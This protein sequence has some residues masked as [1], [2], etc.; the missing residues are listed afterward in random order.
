MLL[1]SNTATGH[2][3]EDLLQDSN[4]FKL[5]AKGPVRSPL[6][7]V[8]LSGVH[9]PELILIDLTDWNEA[10]ALVRGLK[11]LKRRG[12]LIGFRESWNRL[13]Q[14]T[15]EDA[16]IGDLLREP[17]GHHELE[18]AT[19]DA[20]HRGHAVADRN[21]LALLPAKAG[22]G[23]STVA[24]NVAAALAGNHAKKVL[25]IESDRRSG[26]LS[27]ML[28][29][30]NRSGLSEA[31]QQAGEMTPV[32]WQQHSVWVSGIHL[33]P[34]N[35]ARRGPPPTWAEYYQLLRFAQKP[36]DYVFVDLPEVV[37]EATA[38]VV[39]SARAICVVCT[40]EVPSLKMAAQRIAELEACQIPA[41]RIH[42]VINRW[43]RGGLPIED[44]EKVLER[45]VFATLPN[46]YKQVKNA[47]LES[48][49]VAQDSRFA[50][51]CKALAQKLSG[52]PETQSAE[53]K[54]TFLKELVRIA[55]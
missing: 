55:D 20:L 15:F 41:D 3:I 37:N 50:R 42:V 21:I 46:D 40:P 27:I 19:Y 31:L 28:N 36:Y 26:I 23:C 2:R 32:E 1:T 11:N 53:S 49:L 16:G 39:K 38:E 30:Q 4:V 6:E 45:P 12:V 14:V 7:T 51:S 47:I 33:L 13:E 10:S 24:L 18:R 25:L 35:P 5:V 9:N 17:F 22:G 54:F 44:V 43:E 29:L 48:R 34:A 8:R 52:L